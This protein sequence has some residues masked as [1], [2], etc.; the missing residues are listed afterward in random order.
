[1]LFE[2]FAGLLCLANTTHHKGYGD[3]IMLPCT[4]CTGR[5]LV[6]SMDVNGLVQD[7]NIIIPAS[8]WSSYGTVYCEGDQDVCYKICP[9]KHSKCCPL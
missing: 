8:D 1:M 6:N 7:G 2:H 4:G 9:P 5:C 3:S